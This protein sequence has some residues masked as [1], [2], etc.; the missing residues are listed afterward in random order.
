MG[1]SSKEEEVLKKNSLFKNEWKGE[2][3]M[4]SADN[5]AMCLDDSIGHTGKHIDGIAEVHGGYDVG[6]R[7]LEEG[8]LLGFSLEK[9][10]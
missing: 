3:D 9:E 5:L 7:N 10:S 2:Q 1:M 8:M 4:H 6:Q